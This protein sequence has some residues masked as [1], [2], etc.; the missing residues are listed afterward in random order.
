MTINTKFEIGQ[1]VF[2][3]GLNIS[4][5][6]ISVY[7]LNRIEYRVRFF[8]AGNIRDPYFF[9]EELKEINDC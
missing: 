5:T 1:R 7:Y 3:E 6:I 9:E 2:I 8:D 4:G